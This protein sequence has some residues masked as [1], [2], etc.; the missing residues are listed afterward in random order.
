MEKHRVQDVTF[1]GDPKQFREQAESCGNCQQ[2]PNFAGSHWDSPNFGWRRNPLAPL[3]PVAL[4]PRIV[5]PWLIPHDVALPRIP[6][7]K[8]Y[9]QPY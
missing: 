8:K 2:F 6:P 4:H 3:A 7:R 9:L 1:N 5:V